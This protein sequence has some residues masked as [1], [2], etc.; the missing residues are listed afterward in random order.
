MK[1]QCRS[2]KGK[3]SMGFEGENRGGMF[4]IGYGLSI[5][6]SDVECTICS[7]YFIYEAFF[8]T[9]MQL[10]G[11]GCLEMN[12]WICGNNVNDTS[13]VSINMFIKMFVPYFLYKCGLS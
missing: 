3:V 12:T 7:L 5:M 13:S 11:H 10:L 9:L 4:H 1:K 2:T 6:C 8:D